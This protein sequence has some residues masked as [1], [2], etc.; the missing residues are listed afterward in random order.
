[1]PGREVECSVLGN[2]ELETSLPGEIIAD[3]E[4]YDFEAKY[5]EG[6]MSL[7]GTGCDR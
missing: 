5:T 4:W 1:M 6:R 7:V 3:A 2:L